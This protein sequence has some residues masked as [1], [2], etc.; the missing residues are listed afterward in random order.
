MVSEMIKS[1]LPR[2]KG[3]QRKLTIFLQQNTNQYTAAISK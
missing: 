1:S 2:D 3:K